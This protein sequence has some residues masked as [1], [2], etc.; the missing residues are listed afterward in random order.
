MLPV[1]TRGVQKH[2]LIP[3]VG[4]FYK[5]EHYNGPQ[6]TING[7]G[8]VINLKKMCRIRDQESGENSSQKHQILDPVGAGTTTI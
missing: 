3:V 7:T 4:Q 6:E 8:S 2:D 5:R 1:H